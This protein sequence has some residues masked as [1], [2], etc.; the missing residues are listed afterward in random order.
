[1]DF[2]RIAYV[3]QYEPVGATLLIFLVAVTVIASAVATYIGACT[4][5]DM[6]KKKRE[7]R[8]RDLAF[9][10]RPNTR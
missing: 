6:L 3:F 1:M 7:E 10:Q 4:A 9:A 8:M 2:Q 5:H